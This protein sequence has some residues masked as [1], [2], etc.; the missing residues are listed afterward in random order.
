MNLISNFSINSK[1]YKLEI[2]GQIANSLDTVVI[3][4][5]DHNF[6]YLNNI[7]CAAMVRH[8]RGDVIA[9]DQLFFVPQ[10]NGGKRRAGPLDS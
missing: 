6:H 10:P 1:K 3:E 5:E 2:D 8:T 7:G 4:N 9:E